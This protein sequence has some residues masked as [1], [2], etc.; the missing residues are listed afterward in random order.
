MAANVLL[1]A[2]R[3]AQARDPA[4]VS[5]L[6][7]R[8]QQATELA[9][10]DLRAVVRG[11]LPPV[12]ADRGLA[13]ALTGLAAECPVRCRIDVELPGRCAASVEA[14]AYFELPCGS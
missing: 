8:A 7:E 10:A 14:T 3:R 9:L 11:I 12:L 1:G 4:A 13:E 5:D 2:A 6:L